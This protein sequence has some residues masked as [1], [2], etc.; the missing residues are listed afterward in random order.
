MID[1][2]CH[3]LPQLDDGSDSEE[4]SLSQFRLMAEGGIKQVFLTAHF[5]HGYDPRVADGEYIN[6]YHAKLRVLR[7]LVRDNGIDIVLR[8]GFEVYLTPETPEDV[9]RHDLCLGD[10]RYLLLESD[11]N[12]LPVDFYH[13]IYP[14]LRQGYKLIL[15]HA[16]RYVSIMKNPREARKL[17]QQNVH[18]QVNSGSLLG[19]YGNKV[20]E[21]AWL[22]VRN[23]WAHLLGSDDHARKPYGGFFLAR[24]KLEREIDDHIPELLTEEFPRMVAED[25][26]IPLK[27]VYLK[28]VRQPRKRKSLLRRII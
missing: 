14:L 19:D 8:K 2:H 24:E 1:V 21:T 7:S 17:I 28:P 5:K 16:E 27:Y 10:S 9:P 20:R 25:G 12:G 13:S 11:L 26:K 18:I 22:L 6:K 23:G 3:L 15:A 4:K